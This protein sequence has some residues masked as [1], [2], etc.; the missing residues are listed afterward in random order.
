MR[1]YEISDS[2]IRT[3]FR[4]YFTTTGKVSI[5]GGV[6]S[7]NGSCNIKSV[8]SDDDKL[9]S[10]PVKFDV[11]DNNFSC[12]FHKLSNLDGA[13]NVVGGEFWVPG[14][15]LRDLTG[16]PT[17]VHGDYRCQLNRDMSSLK[18]VAKEI[19]GNLDVYGC[20]IKTFDYLPEYIGGFIQLSYN[21]HLPMLKLILIEGLKEV[22]FD[23][24][25]DRGRQVQTI[26]TNNLGKGKGGMLAAAA[27]L[28]KA[29]F[30]G[31]ARL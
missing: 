16:G 12:G 17:K 30:R 11:I 19:G 22:R 8:R 5:I 14:N 4:K 25:H 31:N 1:L 9:T 6:V 29:G 7:V 15:Q 21:Q 24:I 18:G 28:I 10:L 26:L 13:P 3:T 20:N 2:D 23:P 27:E